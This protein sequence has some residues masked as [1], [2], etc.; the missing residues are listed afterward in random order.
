MPDMSKYQ[1]MLDELGSEYPQV[2]DLADELATELES[3]E[4]PEEEGLDDLPELPFEDEELPELDLG[5]Y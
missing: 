1:A 2:A 3:V 4:M 5:G